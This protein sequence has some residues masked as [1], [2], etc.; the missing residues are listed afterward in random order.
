MEDAS[1]Q[2]R[3]AEKA[4]AREEPTTGET[5]AL[6]SAAGAH[7][8]GKHGGSGLTPALDSGADAE[9]AQGDSAHVGAHAD[10]AEAE[11]EAEKPG[12]LTRLTGI[13]GT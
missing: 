10:A 2:S 4:P 11:A 7:E 3:R 5:R 12:I 8:G 9:S 6:A 1:S 13:G